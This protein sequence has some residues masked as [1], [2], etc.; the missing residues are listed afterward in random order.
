[1][2]LELAKAGF[3]RPSH[4]I[5]H[6]KIFKRSESFVKVIKCV[7][8]EEPEGSI[9]QAVRICSVV[10]KMWKAYESDIK[11]LVLKVSGNFINLIYFFL[12]LWVLLKKTNFIYEISISL[13]VVSMVIVHFLGSFKSKACILCLE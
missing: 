1:M 4:L 8:Q 10:R 12:S 3:D 11:C 5:L 13:I 7:I 9:P 2:A 6:L